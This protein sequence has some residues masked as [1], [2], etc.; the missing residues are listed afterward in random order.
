MV[1]LHLGAALA[2]TSPWCGPSRYFTIVGI[3]W[4]RWRV[5]Y[6]CGQGGT[7]RPHALGSC[8]PERNPPSRSRRRPPMASVS[9]HPSVI[10]AHWLGWLTCANYI[11]LRLYVMRSVYK[12]L[13]VHRRLK[14]GAESE[15]HRAAGPL[16][17]L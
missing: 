3:S 14:A 5:R 11:N 12:Q 1:L 6:V 8:E 13:I 17:L 7:P 10:H 2:A 16:W 15:P 9:Y 4:A